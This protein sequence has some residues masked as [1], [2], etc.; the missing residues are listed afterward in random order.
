M[1]ERDIKFSIEPALIAKGLKISAATFS[2]PE[3]PRHRGSGLEEHIQRV[4]ESLNIRELLKSPILEA[5][6]ELQREAGVKRPVAPAEYLLGLIQKSRKLPNI[7]RVVDGYNIVSAATLL[8]MGAHDLEKISGNVQLRTTDSTEKYTPLGKTE[9]E[10]VAPGEYVAIDDKGTV[11]CRLDLKQGN[12]TKCDGDSKK[13][14]IYA[15][16]N[17]ETSEDYL[18]DALRR[19]R[20]NIVNF[21][22]GKCLILE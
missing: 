17:T 21:C 9:P 5:Y 8:S 19:V 4:I 2:V 3:N 6:R 16:G 15:Q 11:L 12:E 13:I 18:R 14:L 10:R 7:N 20:E 1:P 22:N